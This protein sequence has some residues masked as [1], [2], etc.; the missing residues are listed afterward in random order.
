M[1]GLLLLELY[2]KTM[3]QALQVHFFPSNGFLL[4]THLCLGSHKDCFPRGLRYDSGLAHKELTLLPS[5]SR[6]MSKTL[7]LPQ[8]SLEQ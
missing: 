8:R 4:L 5:V 6:F 1:G 3:K 2:K 7:W